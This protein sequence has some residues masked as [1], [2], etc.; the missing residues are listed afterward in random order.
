MLQFLCYLVNYV[1][2]IVW[3]GKLLIL[4]PWWFSSKESACNSGDSGDVG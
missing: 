1:P 3:N 2:L 4:L